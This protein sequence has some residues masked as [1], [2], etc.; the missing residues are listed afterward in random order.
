MIHTSNMKKDPFL[1][2]KSWRMFLISK[3]SFS[4]IFQAK[5]FLFFRWFLITL[6][7]KS[8]WVTKLD[9][10]YLEITIFS[11]FLLSRKQFFC[12]NQKQYF[13]CSQFGIDY[14]HRTSF[15]ISNV[16]EPN[17]NR[18]DQ[19]RLTIS[20]EDFNRSLMILQNKQILPQ[21]K[22]KIMITQR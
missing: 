12:L 3:L 1:T 9:L 18:A 17:Y 13:I 4:L 8:H 22:F 16:F 6:K 14:R 11:S 5:I 20:T 7:G 2:M 10:D 15:S 19:A 21:K